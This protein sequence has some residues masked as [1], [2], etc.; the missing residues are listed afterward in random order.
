M[1]T[2]TTDT[3]PANPVAIVTG[4][5]QG[6]GEAVALRLAE[7][8]FNIAVNDIRSSAEKITAVVNA[9]QAKGRKALAVP[10]DVSVESDVVQIVEKTIQE[11]GGVDVVRLLAG[12]L[13]RNDGSVNCRL[14]AHGAWCR[15]LQTQESSDFS[16]S[17]K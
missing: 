4:A 3:G 6:I 7:D 13:L 5:G 15:W 1:S 17:S 9:I 14:V 16:P 11:L 12:M 8:G 2:V 10:G